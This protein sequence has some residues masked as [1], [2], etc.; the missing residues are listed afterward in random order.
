MREDERRETIDKS[1][2]LSFE[3]V[4]A[5][6]SPGDL[7]VL[8]HHVLEP[9]DNALPQQHLSRGRDDRPAACCVTTRD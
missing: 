6:Y 4:D 7:L 5:S 2:T 9:V 3:S 8:G 1:R